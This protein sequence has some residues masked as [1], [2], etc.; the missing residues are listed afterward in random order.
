MRVELAGVKPGSPGNLE[1]AT[2][3]R[4]AVAGIL[5]LMSLIASAHGQPITQG[6]AGASNAIAASPGGIPTMPGTAAGSTSP[7]GIN[8]VPE[9][10]RSVPPTA[11]PSQVPNTGPM[12]RSTVPP[13]ASAGV[14][15][16]SSRVAARHTARSSPPRR[17]QKA[18][19][20]ALAESVDRK[21]MSICRGC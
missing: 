21:V 5:A 3:S 18:L 16:R 12:L 11:N 19:D 15:G 10:P 7:G 1:Y 9:A 6:T 8:G 2:M 20:R 17:S 14:I 4:S 13:R